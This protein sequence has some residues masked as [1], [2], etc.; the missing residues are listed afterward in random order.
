MID[1]I[2][3]FTQWSK[4]IITSVI[5]VL[6]GILIKSVTIAEGSFGVI[7]IA[8][9]I[10]I[11]VIS[12]IVEFVINLIISRSTRIRRLLL[13]QNFIEGYWV[14]GVIDIAEINRVESLALIKITFVD[15]RYSVSGESFALDNTLRGSF[16]S[17]Y[18]DYKNFCL[19]YSYEGINSEHTD[20]KVV[21]NGELI[22]T[23]NDTYPR[24]LT[25]N[26]IDNF[27]RDRVM[28][29]AEKIDETMLSNMDISRSSSKIT[30]I[31]EYLK[32]LRAQNVS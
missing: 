2:V 7:L 30:L 15:N 29:T 16:H 1:D 22:F 11:I 8:V 19:K 18:S 4:T 6:S 9:F 13:G 5:G 28:V 31:K 21:G 17:V 12:K 32:E 10:L 3:K 25:G 14:E 24:R 20:S 23:P 26:L 27:H